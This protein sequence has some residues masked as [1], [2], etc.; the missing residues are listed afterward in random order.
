MTT[1][2]LDYWT[3]FQGTEF[4]I[5]N[6]DI[7]N[8][9]SEYI[10]TECFVLRKIDQEMRE[11][12]R[13]L[14]TEWNFYS[15]KKHERY[16]KVLGQAIYI[17]EFVDNFRREEIQEN[18]NQYFKIDGALVCLITF[19]TAYRDW[20]Q[21]GSFPVEN[22]LI[23][24]TYDNFIKFI[25]PYTIKK[26]DRNNNKMIGPIGLTR[27]EIEKYKSI[28]K[29]TLDIKDHGGSY[30]T[31]LVGVNES[32]K[33]NILEAMSFLDAEASAELRKT[34]IYKICNRNKMDSDSVTIS[35]H[36]DNCGGITELC[37]N[38]VK[39]ITSGHAYHDINFKINKIIKTV[40]V[41]HG[42]SSF[43]EEIA[44]EFELLEKNLFI[45]PTPASVVKYHIAHANES[46]NKYDKLTGDNFLYYYDDVIRKVIQAHMPKVLFWQSHS[47]RLVPTINL[48]DFVSDINLYP[49]L[50]HIFAISGYDTKGKIRIILSSIFTNSA[51]RNSLAE[52]LS[53]MAT[54]YL[55][56]I[57]DHAIK[58]K[59]SIESNMNCNINILDNKQNNAYYEIQER[60]AG[61]QH[62]IS[63]ILSLSV[64]TKKLGE[65]N[66]LILIDE[67]ENHLHPSATRD[68]GE[69]L[70]KIGESNYLFAATHSPFI[71][72]RDYRERNILVKKDDAGYTTTQPI[73][74]DA[75]IYSDEV[76]MDAFGINAFKDLLPEHRVL[77]EGVTDK[78]ILEKI[79]QTMG[80]KDI[81]ITNC[82]GTRIRAAATFFN[83]KNTSILV[84]T[85]NDDAGRKAKKGVLKIE[86][87]F[88]ENNVF[89]I[90]DLIPSVGDNH[91]IEDLLPKKY[92]DVIFKE[93]C[94]SENIP[95]GF[96]QK[97]NSASF[98]SQV[99]SYLKTHKV[100][101]L[102][103]KMDALKKRLSKNLSLTSENLKNEYKLLY[104]L[105]DAIIKKLD[106]AKATESK[107]AS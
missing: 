82:G 62:F 39:N 52:E 77:V 60:S 30:T 103:N 88:N 42:D 47:V 80:R 99:Q 76:L 105:A 67:P 61:F 55:K 84:L 7:E 86:G 69:E 100:D 106:E 8:F 63:F 13:L 32:G 5:L 102:D 56:K 34:E 10:E 91:T 93:F 38:E 83:D 43:Q 98:V 71:I 16:R 25:D 51:T 14:F 101:Y 33:S 31:M 4:I 66:K 27:I 75:D 28:D 6:L 9:H 89:T 59:I 20:I 74:N 40:Q 73:K 1:T 22:E 53:D 2:S 19:S 68:F 94:K 54:E 96:L 50:K 21:L 15:K 79:F 3:Q 26:I 48:H 72:D 37:I 65:G 78:I 70:I 64:P 44:F 104:E 92:R 17:L 18:F 81:A 35:F 90:Q 24:T 23:H 29:M 87:V 107:T 95:E 85:D 46:T 11:E 12:I 41:T 45:I 58:I 57:W 36:F 49:H 97:T